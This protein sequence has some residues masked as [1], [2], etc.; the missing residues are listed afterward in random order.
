MLLPEAHQLLL[1]AQ[2][3]APLPYFLPCSLWLAQ[4]AAAPLYAQRLHGLQQPQAP[5]FLLSAQAL[6]QAVP[7]AQHQ[8]LHAE[9]KQAPPQLQELLLLLRGAYQVLLVLPVLQGEQLQALMHLP[10]QL[11]RQ[12]LMQAWGPPP[13]PAPL[14]VAVAAPASLP[15]PA[16]VPERA[17]PGHEQTSLQYQQATGLVPPVLQAA[18]LA[19][20]EGRHQQRRWCVRACH[21]SCLP[22]NPLPPLPQLLPCGRAWRCQSCAAACCRRGRGAGCHCEAL[23]ASR[24]RCPPRCLTTHSTRPLLVAWA[25]HQLDGLA[26]PLNTGRLRLVELGSRGWDR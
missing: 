16:Q 14:L 5:L 23:P 10:V 12:Q 8:L 25:G 22:A 11:A 3:H 19:P 7:R 17:A 4:L 24:P 18:A 13:H 9:L 21:P 1:A 15:L 26:P 20:A 6:P 2:L